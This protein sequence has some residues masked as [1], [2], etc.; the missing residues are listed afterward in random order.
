MAKKT[1][2]T[3][4]RYMRVLSRAPKGMKCTYS[5]QR[6]DHDADDNEKCG[7]G[8]PPNFSCWRHRRSPSFLYCG[9]FDRQQTQN[10]YCTAID[11]TV[12]HNFQPGK[13]IVYST[14]INKLLTSM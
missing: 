3:I 4:I 8:E 14:V 11:C 7:N 12:G 13:N 9:T 1:R 10:D 2:C 5:I 6:T